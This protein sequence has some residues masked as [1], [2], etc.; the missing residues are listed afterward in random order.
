M[1]GKCVKLTFVTGLSVAWML[2]SAMATEKNWGKYQVEDRRSGYT[3]AQIEP[4]SMQDDDFENPAMVLVDEAA[5]I[6]E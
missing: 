4:R 3:Y 6:W 5:E 2:G 1:L